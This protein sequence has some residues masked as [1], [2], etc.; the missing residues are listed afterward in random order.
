M[1]SWVGRLPETPGFS[2]SDV[3]LLIANH[4]ATHFLFEIVRRSL[5]SPLLL[6]GEDY[7]ISKESMGPAGFSTERVVRD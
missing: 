5:F 7:F 6:M 1:E 3:S 2:A 4:R